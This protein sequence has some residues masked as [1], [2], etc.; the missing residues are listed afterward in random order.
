MTRL[1]AA[2]IV[3]LAIA[4]GGTALGVAEEGKKLSHDPISISCDDDLSV[5]NGVISGMGVAE[6]PY[7]VSGWE[8]IVQS[9]VGIRIQ[10]TS[11]NVLV[12]D[13]HIT[14]SRRHGIGILLTESANVSVEDCIFVDLQSGVFIYQNA[15]AM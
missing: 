6:D 8:I 4:I 15:G 9:G 5:E 2:L 13:C 14:G 1:R 7:V 10:G 11:A 3:F 12:K